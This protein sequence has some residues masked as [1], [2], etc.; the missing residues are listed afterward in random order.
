MAIFWKCFWPKIYACN[1]YN[2]HWWKH[3]GT[4]KTYGMNTTQVMIKFKL[5]SFS[6]QGVFRM[7]IEHFIVKIFEKIWF[8]L[9]STTK[10]E[11]FAWRMKEQSGRKHRAMCAVSFRIFLFFFLFRTF[12]LR[13]NYFSIDFT[14]CD[15]FRSGKYELFCVEISTKNENFFA[16]CVVTLTKREKYFQSMDGWYN[17]LV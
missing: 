17:L 2:S 1:A 9:V 10:W 4:A 13:F 16:L 12:G 8:G 7:E 6:F 5:K 3:N 15:I 14:Q 11:K